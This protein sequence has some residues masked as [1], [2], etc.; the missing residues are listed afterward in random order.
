MPR[1]LE[2]ILNYADADACNASIDAVEKVFREA[3]QQGVNDRLAQSGVK[4]HVGGNTDAALTAAMRKAAGL[5][6]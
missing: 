6:D 5:P 3:V 2:A 4:L 1:G